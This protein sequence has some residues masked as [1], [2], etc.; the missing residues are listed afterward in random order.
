MCIVRGE[1]RVQRGL[2]ELVLDPAMAAIPPPLAPSPLA[3]FFR[4]ARRRLLLEELAS[5]PKRPSF[6]SANV[7]TRF[8]SLQF[9]GKPSHAFTERERERG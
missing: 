1:A 4:C 8:R 6:E 9:G 7:L 3:P 5:G 2:V